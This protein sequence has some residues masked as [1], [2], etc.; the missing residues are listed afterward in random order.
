[1][2]TVLIA[3]VLI[4]MALLVGLVVPAVTPPISWLPKTSEAGT[5]LGTLL[6][7]QAAI[8]ALTLAVTI[9][10]MQ[11][12]TAR[13]DADD[14]TY[15]EYVRRSW[16]RQ[17]FWGS[18]I[19]VG[20]AG[21]VLLIEGF[22]GAINAVATAFPGLRNLTVIAAIAFLANLLL[23]AILFERAV[24][25]TRPEQWRTMR[26]YVNERDVRD[27][28]RVFLKRVRSSQLEGQVGYTSDL[29]DA[30]P[31]PGEGSASEAIQALLSDGRRAMDERRPWDFA[32]SLDSI[33]DLLEFA[34]REIEEAGIGRQTP[35]L[36]WWPPLGELRDNLASFREEV[37]RRGDRLHASELLRFDHWA[38][39]SGTSRGS[40]D[41]LR[42]GLDGYLSNY[43]TAIRI[44]DSEFLES[45]FAQ[46]WDWPYPTFSPAQPGEVFPYINEQMILYQ[47]RLLSEGMQAGRP[48]D[49]EQIH[50][51]FEVFLRALD[52]YWE[53][54]RS[55]WPET[56]ELYERLVE[57]Y[58]IALIGLG[59][60]RLLLAD[61]GRSADSRAC[62][63]VVRG[64]HS[65]L[66]E[67]AADVA[68]AIT[69]N[70][71]WQKTLWMTWE[72]EGAE[73]MEARRPN[74]WRYPLTWF[75]FRL[76]ELSTE[77][78]QM[79]DLHG[80]AR[81]TLSW[82][83]KN[84][85]ALAAHLRDLPSPTIEE[86]RE[87]ATVALR[88][89]ARRE[90]VA[91]DIEIIR[92]NLSDER[93]SAF[94][95]G[96]HAGAVSPNCVESLFE[97][98]G[99]SLVL[100]I[101]DETGLDEC[102]IHTIETK[103][104]LADVPENAHGPNVQLVGGHWGRLLSDEVVKRFCETLDKV[105]GTTASLNTPEAL[106]G[107]IDE[108]TEGLDASGELI[109]VLAGDWSNVLVDLSVI[110]PEGFQP[111]KKEPDAPRTVEIA[112]YNGHPILRGPASDGRRL[113]IVDPQTWGRLVRA[114]AESDQIIAVKV[115]PISA[116]RAHDLLASDPS[117]FADEPNEASKLRKL[118]T[119]VEIVISERAEFRVTDSSRARRIVDV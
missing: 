38:V 24:H 81:V 94:K 54:Q 63:D 112:R 62:I 35:F 47:E 84:S 21:L 53:H 85:I 74:P 22:V 93:L 32:R 73:N 37:I 88:V 50:K 29:F 119:C 70:N 45:F 20:I 26:R 40:E 18:L 108:A 114:K 10:V 17:I 107:A 72:M 12:A 7:A 6:T 95:E 86:R 60:R 90:E 99:A 115:N 46:I 87:H 109:I 71:S 2:R 13:R 25:L 83:E 111:Q 102:R 5:L 64:A 68:K 51:R 105:I 104:F 82:F 42:V 16:V 39:T 79:I 61:S 49:Y 48:T 55:R 36:P 69:G 77:P 4:A 19:A 100:P 91:E 14:R 103:V 76:M 56:K 67:L 75:T 80:S 9:F 8:A 116:E 66:G 78:S 59:G 34:L 97:R 110:R 44:G 41:L 106:L 52:R 33:K 1:M 113:Y 101:D 23:A 89:A 30:P 92:Y 57:S 58:R 98:A 31:D 65:H 118:Q 96:V 28:V 15:R 43:Q 27:A 3:T 11:G 117:H